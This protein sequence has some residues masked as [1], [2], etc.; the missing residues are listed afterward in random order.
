MSRTCNVERN[1]DFR[2]HLSSH[3][4]KS[5]PTNSI[6]DRS[7]VGLSYLRSINHWVVTN[8]MPTLFRCQ[9]ISYTQ[10]M[11]NYQKDILK[12]FLFHKDLMLQWREFI[13]KTDL[14]RIKL[15]GLRRNNISKRFYGIQWYLTNCLTNWCKA[16]HYRLVYQT[17]FKLRTCYFL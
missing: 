2:I 8:F 1:D 13:Y 15:P 10:S 4:D 9:N 12:P 14:D 7:S 17:G 11:H 6:L 16:T 3:L 5:L